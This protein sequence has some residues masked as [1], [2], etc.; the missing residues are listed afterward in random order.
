MTD[1]KPLFANNKKKFT[2]FLSTL[3]IITAMT[4]SYELREDSVYKS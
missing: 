1:K 2:D 3:F 4:H